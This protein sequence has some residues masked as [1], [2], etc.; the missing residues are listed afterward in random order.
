MTRWGFP[1]LVCLLSLLSVSS[2]AQKSPH[3]SGV[4]LLYHH[5]SADTPRSTSVTTAQFEQHLDYIAEHYSVVPL[6]DLVTAAAGQGSVPDNALAITFDDGYE[7][8]LQNGHP[9]L[10]AHGFPYT[11]FINPAVIGK[12]NNQLSWAQVEAMQKEGASFANHTMDHLHLLEQ[13]I[14]ETKQAWLARVWKNISDA[15]TMIAE[16]TGKSL[17]YLAYPFGEYN[18]TLARKLADN[19][20][21]AFGQHSGAVGSFTDMAAIPRFP[22]AGPYANLDTLK[23]KMASLA[24]PVTSTSLTDPEISERNVKKPVAITLNEDAASL[25]RL[26]QLACYFQGERLPIKTAQSQFEFTLPSTLPIGRSRVNCTAPSNSLSGRFYWY[27]MPF[28]IATKEGK[29][30]D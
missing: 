2:Y 5:V 29:Y 24:M 1:L 18:Q 23:T 21:I 28:F 3:S 16:H 10:K 7:N 4:I 14:G 6:Q 25:V 22:A 9:L 27:S 19:G 30:P 15:E 20:Y 26:S 8:I 12:Q 17:K 13:H 11:V